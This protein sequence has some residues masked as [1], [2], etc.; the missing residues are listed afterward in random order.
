MTVCVKV[1]VYVYMCMYVHLCKCIDVNM[2]VYE[3]VCVHVSWQ[4]HLG[5]PNGQHW[6]SGH[7]T[8]YI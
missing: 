2:S 6:E 8:D 7:I 4:V 5:N 3:H 1:F